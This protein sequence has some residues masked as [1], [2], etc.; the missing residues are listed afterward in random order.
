MGAG[1]RH[2]S[3]GSEMK[4]NLLLS[5]ARVSHFVLVLWALVPKGTCKDGR[6]DDICI[7]NGLWY[8]GIILNVGNSALLEWLAGMPTICA[9][10]TLFSKAAS[11]PVL[12]SGGRCW[13]RWYSPTLGGC[14]QR[15]VGGCD[16]RR[17]SV[18][19]WGP[20]VADRRCCAVYLPQCCR[21][22]WDIDRWEQGCIQTFDRK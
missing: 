1:R 19:R 8:T 10:W 21:Q 15:W 22:W 17:C 14:W 18:S 3:S 11:K 2:K 12:C 5:V 4:D 20:S 7:R 16:V 13:N 6:S 9:R